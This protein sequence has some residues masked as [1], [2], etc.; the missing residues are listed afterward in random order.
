MNSIL[1]R[2]DAS[3]TIGM[4]HL[5]RCKALADYLKLNYNFKI[6][7]ATKKKYF[8]K[9]FLDG[10]YNIIEISSKKNDYSDFLVS[11]LRSTNS[12]ALILDSRDELKRSA[13]KKI[14]NQTNVKIITIDDP[15]DK[16]L[17]AD[18]AFYPPV[19]QL[20]TM[21]WDGFN[22]KLFY[23]WEYVILREQFF[24]KYKYPKNKKKQLLL[25]MGGTDKNDMTSKVVKILKSLKNDFDLKIIV[26]KKYSHSK[27]L[28]E[29]LKSLKSSYKIFN[30]PENI[31]EVMSSSDFA[32]ISFG[33]T[34]YEI[35]ALNIPSIHICISEDHYMSSKLFSENGLAH[36]LTISEAFKQNKLI[37]LIN[38]VVFQDRS[39]NNYIDDLNT[40][41]NLN[42]ISNAIIDQLKTL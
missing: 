31:A 23:G 2:C 27:N 15:Q 32:I 3:E 42:I 29:C 24:K 41:N 8:A 34:A 7:F 12:V 26:G 17:E 28:N 40:Q 9:S 38:S 4:G 22:G 11:S 37:S 16:R 19:P 36:S 18:L 20:K 5:I 1:F 30:N 10:D 13:L 39:E 14:K 6:Y 21:N 25:S 35:R 33:Q